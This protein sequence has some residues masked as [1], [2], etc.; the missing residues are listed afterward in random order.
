[1]QNLYDLHG[2]SFGGEAKNVYIQ[3]SDCSHC[4]TMSDDQRA[5]FSVNDKDFSNELKSIRELVN[6]EVEKERLTFFDRMHFLIR[7]WKGQLPNLR[8][9]F[10][11]EEIDWLLTEYQK[12]KENHYDYGYSFVQFVHATGYKDEPVLDE[13]GKPILRR[14]TTLHY[15]AKNRRLRMSIDTQKFFQIY[16]RFDVNYADESGLSHFHVAC[17]FGCDGAVKKFLEAGQDPNCIWQETGDSPLH[18]ALA[19]GQWYDMSEVLL[20]HGADPNLANKDGSTPLHVICRMN[21]FDETEEL[22]DLFFKLIDEIQQ[23]VQ[24]DARD[25]LGLTPLQWAV[26]SL[27]PATVDA[28]LDR[29][30]DLSSFVFPTESYFGKIFDPEYNY[31]ADF[32]VGSTY[33]ALDVVDRLEKRGYEINRSDAITIMKLFAKY[34]VFVKPT[35]LDTSWCDDE[36]YTVK[37]KETMKNFNFSLY[38]LQLRPKE[39]GKL[40]TKTNCFD[41]INNYY[42]NYHW[43][44]SDWPT[45][46]CAAHLAEIIFRRF[47]QRWA[48]DSLLELTHYQLP[49]LCCEMIIEQLMN[50]DFYHIC[51]AAAGQNS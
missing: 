44:I 19:V 51:L 32:T 43:R 40:I 50:T 2:L 1:M 16:D 47:Y 34:G 36:K 15:A 45:E 30:A 33:D 41:V 12:N 8:D 21:E 9:I 17:R 37:V 10:R 3:I 13:D 6:W 5:A 7:N 23:T 27:L 25:N 39:V 35:N 4:I 18:L 28:L 38:L 42:W 20:R 49:I 22:V 11:T 48:L 24:I 26:A 14:S 31:R 46:A 29:G